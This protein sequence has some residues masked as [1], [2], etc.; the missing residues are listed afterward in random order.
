MIDG[1]FW[2]RHL[3]FRDYLRARPE[4]AADYERLKREFAAIHDDTMA[5]A[6]AKSD[7][8]RSIEARARAEP[9]GSTAGLAP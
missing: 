4:V 7:F 6:D 3:L 5:Y 1:E 2:E 9:G 8:V